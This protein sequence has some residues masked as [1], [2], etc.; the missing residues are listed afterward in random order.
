MT[1]YTV[2]RT[3]KIPND[4]SI[5]AVSDLHFGGKEDPE[6]A[7]RFCRFL[8]RITAAYTSG[9]V[10]CKPLPDGTGITGNDEFPR[11]LLPPKKII[12]LGDI[13]ELWDTR[14]RDRNN[15]MLDAICP[16][17]HLQKLPCD[18]VY[19]TGNHDEDFSEVVSSYDGCR[20]KQC[21]ALVWDKFLEPFPPRP[22]CVNPIESL[23]I[24]WSENQVFE[25]SPRHYPSDSTAGEIM[26]VS[27][28]G[29]H[30]AFLHGQQFDREQITYSLGQALGIRVDIVDFFEDLANVS[31]TKQMGLVSHAGNLVLALILLAVFTSPIYQ[32]ERIWTGVWTGIALTAIFLF[33][34]TLFLLWKK[35]LPS[36]PTLGMIFAIASLCMVIA[37]PVVWLVMPAS[38]ELLYFI[39]FFG[40][41]YIL[42]VMSAPSLFSYSKKTIYNWL[43]RAKRLSAR[44][45]F[46]DGLF[47][48]K[49]YNYN[50]E[51]L[52]FGHTH[53]PDDYF[54]VNTGET[55][56][57][58]VLLINTGT[59]VSESPDNVCD[60]F[61]YIDRN[62]VSSMRWQDKTDTIF[63][64]KF[65]PSQILRAQKKRSP[66]K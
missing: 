37:I 32:M 33:C 63:C 59:W 34:A 25:I 27:S 36:S 2:A 40:S 52:V 43:S 5:I 49:K 4:R 10:P 53:L 45:I 23:K 28:G 22:S 11:E 7:T 60:S 57:P 48:C 17:L 39:P 21:S 19:V 12:L 31:V 35:D 20:K 61:V 8:E 18:V 62:G 9:P 24:C 3:E 51:V 30:Y 44:K 55:A 29:V 54:N 56:P 14:E 1:P 15:A 13:F 6:T 47:Q 64:A 46:E 42:L 26:G 16:M 41:W 50:A 66:S 38:F 65:F 58:P